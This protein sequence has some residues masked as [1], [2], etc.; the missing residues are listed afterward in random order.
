ML[1][2]EVLSL[3]INNKN[4]YETEHFCTKIKTGIN[5]YYQ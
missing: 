2:N 4:D 1:D 3:K 5:N